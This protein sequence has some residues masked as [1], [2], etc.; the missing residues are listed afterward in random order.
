M[1]ILPR[2]KFMQAAIFGCIALALAVGFGM[3]AVF[4]VV[5][6]RENTAADTPNPPSTT[7]VPYNSSASAV[8]GVWLFFLVCTTLPT[9]TYP[10]EMKLVVR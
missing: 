3:L 1:P 5:T 10:P 7:R 9:T 2:A 8:A 6:A 4:C